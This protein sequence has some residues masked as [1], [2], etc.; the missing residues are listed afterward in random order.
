MIPIANIVSRPEALVVASMLEAAGIIVR[1]NGEHHAS[2]DPISIALGGYR[3]TVPDWQLEDASRILGDT[4][5]S[6]GFT[7][8]EG[9]QTAVIKLLLV[10]LST[11]LAIIILTALKFGLSSPLLLGL[12]F[13][14]ALG[15]PVNPQGRSEYCVSRRLA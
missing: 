5:G 3:L 7:F 1:I 15:T 2:V 11:S 12:P 6:A 8:S 9:L 14:Q 4:F 13:L 10:Y